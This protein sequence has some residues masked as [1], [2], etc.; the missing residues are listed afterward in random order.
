MS[1]PQRTVP[2]ATTPRPGR[3][4][5]AARPGAGRRGRGAVVRRF[6]PPQHGAWAMLLLPLLVGMWAVGAH[7]LHAALGVAWLSGYALSYYLLQAVKSRR[8][9]RYRAQIALYAAVTVPPAAVVLLARPAVLWY[10]PAFALLL[11][12]NAGYAYR[13]RE[14]ALVNDLASVAQ[15]C[16]MVPLA[17]S[18]AGVPATEVVAP[19]A[20]V[21]LYLVGTVLYVKTMIRERDNPAY[22]VASRAYHV[23]AVP[24]AAWLS[25]VLGLAF[26]LLLARAWLLPGR[27][28][29][30]KVVGLVEMALSVVI[31]V[32]TGLTVAT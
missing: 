13:R 23:A 22:L 4:T 30:P 21:A 31:F 5:K 25:P 32:T 17:A 8:P 12:V 14:R 1:T 27:G 18:V 16:L 10:A 9:S 11:A 2:P 20:A 19:L 29:A 28:L 24:A 6:V 7:P 15:S 26:G 3:S